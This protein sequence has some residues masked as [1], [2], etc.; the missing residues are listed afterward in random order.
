MSVSHATV[1]SGRRRGRRRGRSRRSGPRLVRMAFGDRLGVKRTSGCHWRA[2]GYRWGQTR[3]V[4]PYSV[5][6]SR[7]MSCSTSSSADA[8]EDRADALRDRQ[9]DAE[10]LR[11]VSQHGRGRQALDDHADLRTAPPPGDT[12]WAMSSPARRLRP[13]GAQHVT[14]RSPIPA[15]PAN[16]SGRAPAASAS[17]RISARPR[18][19]RAALRVVAEPQAVGAAGRERDDV[20]G[21]RAELDARR[22]RRSHRRGRSVEWTASWRRTASSRSSLATTAAAGSP[23]TISSAMFGPERTA[24]GRPRRASRAARRSPGR[25]P[26]SGSGRAPSPGSAARPRRTPCSAPRRRRGRLRK[27]RLGDR[28]GADTVRSASRA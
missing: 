10:P 27:G 24:T 18:A 6:G 28:R 23:R 9:L 15:S 11:D 20:L 21:R 22:R 13:V 1:R 19:T 7:R 3:G 4:E 2:T 14:M 17:R 8:L 12:P 5:V 26:S 16:V 25:A